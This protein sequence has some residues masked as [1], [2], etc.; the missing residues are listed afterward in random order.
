MVETDIILVKSAIE[1]MKASNWANR[2]EI[3]RQ[4]EEDL[5][6]LYEELIKS[7]SSGYED[8]QTLIK[9][10]DWSESEK[11]RVL[12][13]LREVNDVEQAEEREGQKVRA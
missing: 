7:Y 8:A 3:I 6:A 10:S 5:D 2:S 4:L 11:E 12:K 13:L 1:S 9:I